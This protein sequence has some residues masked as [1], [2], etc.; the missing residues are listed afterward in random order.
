MMQRLLAKPLFWEKGFLPT[1]VRCRDGRDLTKESP[2]SFFFVLRKLAIFFWWCVSCMSPCN[3]S[4]RAFREKKISRWETNKFEN[5]R[6]ESARM[7]E[8]LKLLF[9]QFLYLTS[10]ERDMSGPILGVLSNNRWS[11][12]TLHTWLLKSYGPNASM[13][14]AG[15]G[16]KLFC[17]R[18]SCLN[19]TCYLS[20]LLEA[21]NDINSSKHTFLNSE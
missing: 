13:F 16:E 7:L 6:Y 1:C 12:G 11:W 18:E 19:I 2:F 20:W 3:T 14:C 5:C 8:V 17:V 4:V 10:S 21:S 15:N 9:Q